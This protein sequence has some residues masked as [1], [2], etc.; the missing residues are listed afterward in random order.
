[1]MGLKGF[2]VIT[3]VHHNQYVVISS[4]HSD[5][6]QGFLKKRLRKPLGLC[7]AMELDKI[8]DICINGEPVKGNLYGKE[9][10]SKYK[11]ISLLFGLKPYMKSSKVFRRFDNTTVI[12]DEL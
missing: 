3:G 5:G 8:T 9:L 12:K 11:T 10:L 4:S 2:I 1:M 6:L 7:G